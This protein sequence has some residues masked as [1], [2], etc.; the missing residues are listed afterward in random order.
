MLIVEINFNNIRAYHI[1]VLSKLNYMVKLKKEIEELIDSSKYQEAAE[2]VAKEFGITMTAEFMESRKYFDDDKEV[3][4]VYSITLCVGPR[5][6][7]F[8]F[9][10]S[11]NDSGFYV[12]QGKR[13]TYLD[14]TKIKTRQD[15]IMHIN[16]LA[17]PINMYRGLL[18][19]A[20]IDTIHFPVVPTMYD[21]LTCLTKYDPDSFKN[22]CSEYGYDKM[23]DK[24]EKTYN[25]VYDD[26]LNVS[27]LFNDE[28]LE[29][30][31]LIQ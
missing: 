18:F 12:L 7:K 1:F 6:Y 30:L 17:G 11:L 2:L 16:A 27:R 8:K 14:R 15:A 13:K 21:I 23:S 20:N 22:F 29:V 28:Q 24:A 19:D 25:A 31:K 3:R 4:D 9:G 5:S 10:Q 26:W